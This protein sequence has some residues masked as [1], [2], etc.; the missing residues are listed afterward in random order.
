MKPTIFS[1]I[2][3]ILR[4]IFPAILINY[5]NRLETT[6][7]KCSEDW[8]RDYIK[9]FSIASIIIHIVDFS[10]GFIATPKSV[11]IISL[12]LNILLSL[13]SIVVIYSMLTYSNKL[14]KTK[15]ECSK[16][17]ERQMLYYY[18]IFVSILIGISVIAAVYTIMHIRRTNKTIKL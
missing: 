8:R 4:L 1:F 7:C 13:G 12:I 17:W 10:L 6:S 5:V 9:F 16:S 2:S 18:S 15:C 11:M 3:L 14:I